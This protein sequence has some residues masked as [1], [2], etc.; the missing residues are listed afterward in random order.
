MDGHDPHFRSLKEG[1][2]LS[3]RAF[4][5]TSLATGFAVGAGPL[6]AQN[7]I[8]TDAEGLVAGE[9]RIRVPGGELP[10]YR[11][12]PARGSG[13]G[14]VMVVHEV[15][16]VHEH[17]KDVCRR[18]AK[19]GYYGI[20]VDLFARGGNAAAV[21]DV[22]QL[23]ATIVVPTPDTQIMGD[24]DAAASFAAQDGGDAAKLGITGFCWGGRVV[25]MYAAHS[26]ALKAGVAWYGPLNFAPG[27]QR[28]QQP[29][30]IAAQLTAPVLGLYGGADNGIPQEQVEQLRAALRAANKPSEIHV[31]P[32]TPHAFYADYRP[33]YRAEAAR[34]GWQRMQDWFRRNGVTPASG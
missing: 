16:G 27:P 19:L 8:T 11:A 34:D 15:W 29:R 3:R 7:V 21:A 32:D 6:N 31:Y 30:D 5:L 10:A 9:V 17:F 26:R 2:N 18:L 28:P 25:W 14:I 22:Q 23:I 4:A 20:S 24:L 12:K 33:S 1:A 13:F